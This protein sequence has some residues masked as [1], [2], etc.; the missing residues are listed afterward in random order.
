MAVIG[1]GHLGQAHARI[2]AD[3]PEVELVGVADANP[4]QAQT[5]ANRHDT[6]AYTHFG[7]LLDKVDAACIVV[8]TVNHHSVAMSFLERGIPLLIEKPITTTLEQADELIATA[9]RTG[10]VIQV[11]HIERF[12]PAFEALQARPIRPKFIE[13]E[14]H[15]PF[16]GRSTDIGAVLDLMIHDLD[17]INALD[18]TPV[19]SVEAMGVA[20]FGGHEDM[21][22]ARLQFASGCVA[23]VTA[24]RIAPFPKRR[25]RIWAPEGYVGIDFVHR[26]I[27]LVQPSE[28][29]RRHGLDVRNLDPARRT[30]LQSEVFGRHLEMHHQTCTASADQLTRELQDFI[31]CV[32]TGSSPRVTG[33]DGRAALAL[34]TT[35]LDRVRNHQWEGRGDGACGM[36]MPPASGKLFRTADRQAA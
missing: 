22:N 31:H 33:E 23:H 25:L 2:L 32:R 10:A 6:D 28:D 16:T 36:M 12:N 19:V 27:S 15:G 26:K 8:N 35:V 11:G 1:V 29:L 5:V 3:L 7:P 9:Q 24:S 30:Q 14:R 13:S 21:V 17:L 4:N 20:V 34:A 18:R